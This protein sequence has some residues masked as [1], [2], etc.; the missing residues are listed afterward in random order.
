MAMFGCII[1][2]RLV[3]TNMQQVDA[4]KYVF[5][6]EDPQSINH[7][8]VF[9]TGVQAFPPGF[10]ATVHFLW[11]SP[12]AAPQWQ[13]LGMLSNEKPSAIFKLGGN[14]AVASAFTN[15]NGMSPTTVMTPGIAATS[16][17]QLGISVES[18]DIVMAQINTLHANSPSRNPAA[19]GAIVRN[20]DPMKLVEKVL[21]SL[22]NFCSSF[23]GPLPPMSTALF[24]MDWGSTFIPLKALQDWYLM[25]QRKLKADPSG[26]SIIRAD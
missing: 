14:K 12:S 18:I 6:L 10:A 21:E 5:D 20:V 25:M 11:P 22:Y 24:G 17:A 1:A 3:Q 16:P 23:A 15:S 7:I 13:L 8:V 4:T 9:M 26:G 19:A 2:G